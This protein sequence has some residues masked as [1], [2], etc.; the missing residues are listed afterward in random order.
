VV[1]NC[2]S[3]MTNDSNIFH[4]LSTIQISW[5]K[6]PIFVHF[7]IG[8]FS[9]YW[10]LSVFNIYCILVP[11]QVCICKYF[12]SETCLQF[13]NN[14]F[15]RGA[16]NFDTVQFINFFFN[17]SCFWYVSKVSLLNPRSQR[18]FSYFS[19]RSFLNSRFYFLVLWRL[20]S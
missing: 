16:F 4:V 3:L 11:Y 20:S 10:L 15:W 6:Y 2:I 9:Y 19:S 14:A 8:L 5:M 13:L 1:L 17:G 12:L 18:F 7:Y